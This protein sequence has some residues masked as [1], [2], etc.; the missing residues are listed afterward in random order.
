M[1]DGYHTGA[2]SNIDVGAINGQKMA[3]A[4]GIHE[5]IQGQRN[6]KQQGF[7]DRSSGKLYL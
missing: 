5:T 4:V 3:E 2:D 7:K 1:L 6:R